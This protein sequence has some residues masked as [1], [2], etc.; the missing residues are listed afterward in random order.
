[1]SSSFSELI[2]KSVRTSSGQT[3]WRDSPDEGRDHRDD[4]YCG[5]G[6]SVGTR[7]CRR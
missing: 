7:Q 3:M 6:E 2:A 4:Q 5:I 1:M